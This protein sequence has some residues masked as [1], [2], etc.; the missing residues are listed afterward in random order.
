MSIQNILVPFQDEEAGAIAFRAGA[1]F[2]KHFKAHMDVVHIRRPFPLPAAYHY[3]IAGAYLEAH[4]GDIA[5]Q[6]DRHAEKLQ[7]L[8]ERLCTEQGV[9]SVEAAAHAPSMG[10]TTAWND[11]ATSLTFNI[12]SRARLADLSV[13]ALSSDKVKQ[14]EETLVGELIFQSG[15]PVLATSPRKTLE[16]FPKII[17]IAWDGGREAARALGAALP[18]LKQAE[19]VFVTAVD[20]IKPGAESPERAAAYLRLHDVHAQP[21]RVES[22]KTQSP[23]QRFIEHVEINHADLIVMGAYSHNR[24]REIILGGFTRHVLKHAG[25]PVILMH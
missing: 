12:A 15:R 24:W 11:L 13:A 4:A 16:A 20:H 3:P 18:I 5:A 2:A 19:S 22:R 25:A 1:I 23:E 10:A 6:A 7:K 21:H 17:D 9:A 8:H 14:E